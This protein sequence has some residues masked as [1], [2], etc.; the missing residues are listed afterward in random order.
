MWEDGRNL[1][2][3]RV[4]YTY[5]LRAIHVP[6]S[7]NLFFVLLQFQSLTFSSL[8]YLFHGRIIIVHRVH[9]LRNCTTFFLFSFFQ[10][11]KSFVTNFID[12]FTFFCPFSLFHVTKYRWELPPKKNRS[13]IDQPSHTPVNFQRYIAN[14]T[15]VYSWP[16]TYN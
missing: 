8:H 12:P 4:F 6:D 7:W 13:L 11:R 16:T 9:C 2:F 5:F 15:I 1:S 10:S 14:H 3:W